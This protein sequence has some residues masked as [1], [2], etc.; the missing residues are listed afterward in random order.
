MNLGFVKTNDKA[1]YVAKWDSIGL[2]CVAKETAMNKQWIQPCVLSCSFLS[3]PVL[4]CPFLSFPVLP[5]LFLSFPVLSC[6]Y[7]LHRYRTHLNQ[8]RKI[9]L[10][11]ILLQNM[12]LKKV[13]SWT[14]TVALIEIIIH[15]MNSWQIHKLEFLDF[16]LFWKISMLLLLPFLKTIPDTLSLWRLAHPPGKFQSPSNSCGSS[17]N[18]SSSPLPAASAPP[19]APAPA[20]AP[21]PAPAPAPAPALLQLQLK[22]QL[23][24]SSSLSYQKIAIM[25]ALNCTSYLSLLLLLLLLSG[26]SYSRC[27]SPASNNFEI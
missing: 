3:F 21:T 8:R 23:Y 24:F 4:S 18:S 10:V 1:S 25:R 12:L 14:V 20:P 15:S 5:C 27:Q 26:V 17:S 13:T 7:S 6:H 16:Q 22:L 19:P 11:V 2:F 9:Y